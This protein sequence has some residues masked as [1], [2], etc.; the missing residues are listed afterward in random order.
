MD[1]LKMD[2]F[3]KIFGVKFCKNESKISLVSFL[4]SVFV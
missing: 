3:K 2:A 1:S 4:K